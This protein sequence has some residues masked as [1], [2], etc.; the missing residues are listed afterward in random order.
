MQFFLYVSCLGFAVRV[1]G[2]SSAQVLLTMLLVD[3]Q[4]GQALVLWLRPRLIK[5]PHQGQSVFGLMSGPR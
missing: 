2:G 3:P 5:G 4:I 1:R